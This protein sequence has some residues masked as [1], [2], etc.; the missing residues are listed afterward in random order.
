MID[1]IIRWLII[2]LIGRRTVI[3]NATITV[4]TESINENALIVNCLVVD[5]SIVESMTR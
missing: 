4:F 2:R 5:N 1:K 3:A